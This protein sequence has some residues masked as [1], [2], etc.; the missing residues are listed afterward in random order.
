M[1]DVMVKN[2]L[3]LFSEIILTDF[4]HAVSHST[5]GQLAVMLCNHQVRISAD[6]S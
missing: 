4:S 1:F 5:G 3:F 6:H 2:L